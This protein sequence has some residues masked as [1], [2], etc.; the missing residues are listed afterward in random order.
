MHTSWDINPYTIGSIGDGITCTKKELSH[1]I[2]DDES[3]LP[4]S[5][6]YFKEATEMVLYPTDIVFYNTDVYDSWW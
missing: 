4:V 3:V 6:F 5:I 1:F 2:Y